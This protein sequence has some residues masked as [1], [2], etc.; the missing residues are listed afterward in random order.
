MRMHTFQVLAGCVICAS[1]FLVSPVQAKMYKWVDDNGQTHYG[2]SIPKKYLNKERRELNAQGAVVKKIDRAMTAKERKEKKR[3]EA[4]AKAKEKVIMEQKKRDRVLL[5][6]YT[7]ER[8]LIIARD[9]RIDAVN[10]QIQLS[11][12]IIESA[13]KK[14]ERT[15]KQI[16]N[17]K[18]RNK[19]VPMDVY[20]KLERE[21]MQ[22][23]TH[24]KVADGH[25]NKRAEIKT[26]FDDYIIRFKELKS[27]KKK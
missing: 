23:E 15:E 26:Q 4:I 6:T 7:T 17:I 19:D 9:A 18:A 5:D 21:K 2:D 25:K 20:A 12:S 3:Q 22:L 14:L 1:F 24:N 13:T 10:S 8:D 11:E 27:M 16:A